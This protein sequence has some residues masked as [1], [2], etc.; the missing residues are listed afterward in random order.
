MMQNSE[1]N[2]N[3]QNMNQLRRLKELKVIQAQEMIWMIM[4]EVHEN[5][6]AERESS[7]IDAAVVTHVGFRLLYP[8]A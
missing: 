4:L 1:S 2:L 5:N 3:I 8:A 6:D 7:R